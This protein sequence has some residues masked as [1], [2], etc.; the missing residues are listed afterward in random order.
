MK[1]KIFLVLI[2]LVVTIGATFANSLTEYSYSARVFDHNVIFTRLSSGKIFL[3]LG[4]ILHQYRTEQVGEGIK[5][6]LKE[7]GI[8]F[9][10]MYSGD[11]LWVE[12]KED[13]NSFPLTIDFCQPQWIDGEVKQ[14]AGK[15]VYVV[16]GGTDVD[17][18]S[19]IYEYIYQVP[20]CNGTKI[21]KISHKGRSKELSETFKETTNSIKI[22]RPNK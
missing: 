16:Q 19:D 9:T 15:K 22:R 8:S 17:S 1:T 13:I 21:L 11:T 14:F 4:G 2:L 20:I 12:P 6:T 18:P 7:D 10:I 3:R 5:V